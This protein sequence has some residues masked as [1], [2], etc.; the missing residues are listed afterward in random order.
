MKLEHEQQNTYGKAFYA[1]SF[2]HNYHIE[3]SA[4]PSIYLTIPIIN[5]YENT[6]TSKL[7][8]ENT[9]RTEK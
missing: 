2:S 5:V 1:I 6:Q 7:C 8:S 4:L 3:K 9:E